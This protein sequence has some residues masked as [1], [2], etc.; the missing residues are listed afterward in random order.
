MSDIKTFR[1]MLRI[2]KHRLD[3]ELEIQR[4]IQDRIGS[5]GS[6]ALA[7]QLDAE[8][9]LDNHE[10]QLLLDLRESAEKITNDEIKAKIQ[11]NRERKQLALD[12]HRLKAE[13][14]EWEK[15]LKCWEGR[16][17]DLRALS[18]LWSTQYFIIDSAHQRRPD[19][20]TSTRDA[21]VQTRRQE[22][23]YASEEVSERRDRSAGPASLL[24][25]AQPTEEAAPTRRR[26]PSQ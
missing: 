6:R 12:V 16:G 1:N 10:A 9:K 3:D 19:R 2:N 18:D 26:R 4:E 20:V 5:E 13:H 23:R 15:L 22:V 11:T 24:Y 25:D 14:L 7:R 17:Y 8:E 21:E